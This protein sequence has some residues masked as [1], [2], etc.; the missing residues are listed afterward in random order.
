MY[1]KE[2]RG[3]LFLT[4]TWWQLLSAGLMAAAT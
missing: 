4:D 3:K 1:L 2:N